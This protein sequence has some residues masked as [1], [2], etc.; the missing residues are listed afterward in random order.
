MLQKQCLVVYSSL[1][2]DEGANT[3]ISACLR[4]QYCISLAISSTI[5]VLASCMYEEEIKY[6]LPA[7][8]FVLSIDLTYHEEI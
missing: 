1:L 5:T 3:T 8:L 6:G 7:G 4:A 2:K